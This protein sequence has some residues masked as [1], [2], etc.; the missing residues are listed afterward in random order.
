MNY[1]DTIVSRQ[2]VELI[3]L[4]GMQTQTLKERLGGL[5]VLER[6]QD[7]QAL[8]ITPCNSIHTFGMKYGLDLV[9]LDKKN[10][11]CGLVNNVKPWRMSLCLKAHTTMELLVG[12]IKQFDI[13]LG[14]SC[15]WQD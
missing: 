9:Y 11:V 10:I 1:G 5:L 4:Q 13:R 3:R 14:D 12:S 15:L 2:G 8:W 7:R 6:L